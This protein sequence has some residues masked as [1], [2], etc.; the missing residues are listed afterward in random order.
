MTYKAAAAGLPLGGGKA[1]IIGDPAAIKSEA[2]LK[3]Y[4]RFVDT[5]GGRY[6][7]AEDVGTT[8]ADMDVI[9]EVTE[10]VTGTDPARGGS[11]DPSEATAEGVRWAM[12]A[13]VGS[14][15]L[16]GLR[17]V[18]SGAG[19]VGSGLARRLVAD[20][21]VVLV[22]DTDRAKV[23]RL[24]DE[25]DVTVVDP[26]EAHRTPADVF[27]PCALGAV[28]NQK[29]IPELACTAVVGAANNQLAEPADAERLEAAGITYAPDFVVNAGGII[30]ITDELSGAGYDRDRALAH[31]AR[32]ADT[33][34]EVLE[35]AASEAITTT[36]AA[37]RLAE[38][39][40]AAAGQGTLRRFR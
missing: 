16:A 29:T 13:V 4:G 24:R 34:R 19:K 20:G 30:N 25:L 7:T 27:S 6:L 28:L 9:R 17:V 5:L 2:L 8:Q 33:V 1:V 31:V 23:E 32:V 22:S 39:R 15:D 3:A 38:R 40:I 11:G 37:E 21:A 12:K 36:H 26:A 35:I 18:I 10:A 14:D